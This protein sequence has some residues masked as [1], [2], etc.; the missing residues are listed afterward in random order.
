M[1]AVFRAIFGYC[2]LV[3]VVRSAGRRPGKQITPLDFVFIF[4]AGGVTLTAMVG[5]DRSL[6]NAI[7]I[8]TTIAVTHFVLAWVTQHWDRFGLLIDGTPL[9]L[10]QNGEWQVQT[11]RRMRI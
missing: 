5:N 2:F 10:L 3:L 1:A 11:M 6:A 4:F 8:I 7:C 9:V